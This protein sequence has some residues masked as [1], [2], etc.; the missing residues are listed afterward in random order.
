MVHKTH[1][2]SR[3]CSIYI[4]MLKTPASLRRCSIK[5]VVLENLVKSTGKHLCRSRFLNKVSS[6]RPEALESTSGGLLL[7]KTTKHRNNWEPWHEMGW[8]CSWYLFKY[9]LS[10]DSNIINDIFVF[11]YDFRV[12]HKIN[13]CTICKDVYLSGVNHEK[14][15]K[16]LIFENKKTSKKDL[17]KNIMG[18][19]SFKRTL[20]A[21]V[22]K[23]SWNYFV[24]RREHSHNF[25]I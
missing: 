22:R 8:K 4:Q 16:V 12:V 5:K 3:W 18:R 7:Q 17:F 2:I 9:M 14:S 20:L 15:V 13:I 25:L 21:H 10:V 1:P 11:F 24:N 23:V 6:V 19:M